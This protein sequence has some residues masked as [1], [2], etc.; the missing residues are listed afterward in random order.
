MKP[1]LHVHLRPIDRFSHVPPF[2]HAL[3]EQS[4]TDNEMLVSKQI[5]IKTVKT[6]VQSM[7]SM[8]SFPWMSN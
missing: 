7:K 3:L 2:S 8:F 5:S 6:K 1:G 4:I